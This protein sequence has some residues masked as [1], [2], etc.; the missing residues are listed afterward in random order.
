MDRDIFLQEPAPEISHARLSLASGVCVAWIDVF[1]C[2]SQYL[3]R[4]G[5]RLIRVQRSVRADGEPA[6]FPSDAGLDDVALASRAPNTQA[7]SGEFSIPIDGIRPTGLY[8][9]DGALGD[10]GDAVCYGIAP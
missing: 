4:A 6:Q 5:A 1:L 8:G 3:Q 2:A 7:E 9:I 10:T